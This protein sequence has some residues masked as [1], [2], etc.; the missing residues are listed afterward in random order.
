MPKSDN[1]AYLCNG[2][3]C[4]KQ[5][6]K[7]MTPEEWAKYP[8]HHTFDEKFAKTNVRRERKFQFDGKKYREIERK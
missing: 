3:G 5:C 2:E 1:Y 8:C 4:K 6:A 7:T